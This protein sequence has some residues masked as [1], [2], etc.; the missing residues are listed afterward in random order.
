MAYREK[1]LLVVDDTPANVEL[2]LD[3]LEDEGFTH[4]KGVTDPREVLSLCENAL[5]A[6]ILL[7]IRMPHLD[8]YTVIEQLQARFA[9]QVPPIIILTAQ[10]DDNT[11]QRALSMGVRDFITKPFKQ[12]EVLQR[13]QNAIDV[14]NRYQI[15]SQ[16]A[17]TLERLVAKRTRALERLTRLDP[18][19]G[20][21]NR[22]SL[23]GQ[24]RRRAKAAQPT[25]LAFIMLDGM[26]AIGQ[27][28]GHEIAERF[29]ESLSRQLTATLTENDYLGVWGGSALVVITDAES[30][31]DDVRLIQ[32]LHPTLSGSHRVSQLLLSVSPRI[33][34]SEAMQHFEAERLVQQ[35]ALSVPPVAAKHFWQYYS[36]PLEEAQQQRY[37][38]QQ[39]LANAVDNQQL[40]LV[41]QPKMILETRQIVGVEAL[42]RWQHADHGW[43]S[44]GVFIPL[45][46]ASG[47]ILAIGDWVVDEAVR[48]A[49]AWRKTEQLGEG[50]HIAVNVA[51]RQLIQEDFAT[52]LLAK[53]A[54][55][56]LPAS[57]LSIEV[58]ESGLMQDV[59]QAQKQLRQLQATGIQI[60]IDD[61]GTGYSSLAYL[62]TLPFDTLK[63]DRSFIMDIPHSQAD[64]K[65]VNTVISLA[66]G[67]G[68]S[69]VAEGIEKETQEAWLIANGCEFAQG[70]YYDRPLLPE[71]LASKYFPVDHACPA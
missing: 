9:D 28:H 32:R 60:A 25:R 16:Q 13:I 12:D 65:L 4:V 17:K 36:L 45:A 38:L 55:A 30:K 49:I 48:Q 34:L 59:G 64:Q 41:Y 58:T 7:D 33:G 53:L 57:L 35:A 23:L 67:F 68:C 8:G 6:L 1:P 39:A 46:E 15:R 69:L 62:K 37:Q 70:Y 63:I 44:P 14:E 54:E 19:T 66:R 71:Q 24:L 21:P 5:P 31:K 50:F 18:A 42:L 2:M 11:R 40:Q 56:E 22:R 3:L 10:I 61:F 51:A 29:L 20:L 27:L 26:D 52:R 43:I 47:D